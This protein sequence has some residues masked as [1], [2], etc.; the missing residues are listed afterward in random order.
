MKRGPFAKLV[1]ADPTELKHWEL[2]EEKP[3]EGIADR[4]VRTICF[5]KLFP[6]IKLTRFLP[7]LAKISTRGKRHTPAYFEWSEGMWRESKAPSHVSK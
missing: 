2:A 6:D 4:L 1:G 5:A 3:L 7:Y